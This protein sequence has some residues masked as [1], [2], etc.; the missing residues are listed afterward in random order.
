M[1]RAKVNAGA[2]RHPI[3]IQTNTETRDAYGG[4]VN[5]W[6]TL[7]ATRAS[8]TPTNGVERLGSEQITADRGYE[9]VIRT[10]P[11]QT[12]T[13][14]DRITWDSRTFDIEVV[15]DFEERKHFSRI[16]A[17]EREL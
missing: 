7:F 3:T 12:V 15:L 16:T 14:R 6:A 9:F 13:P 10:S 5:S 8:I 2:L 4:V 11:S 17:V 1:P